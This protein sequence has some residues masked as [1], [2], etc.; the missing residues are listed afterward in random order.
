MRSSVGTGRSETAMS[1]YKTFLKLSLGTTPGPGSSG[2][3]AKAHQG[4]QKLSSRSP[5]RQF[6]FYPLAPAREGSEESVLNFSKAARHR[7]TW[8]CKPFR[9]SSV[10]SGI[11]VAG[12]FKVLG[13]GVETELVPPADY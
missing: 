7:A 13:F 3:V 12:E 11:G 4:I 9:A 2:L 1:C 8:C 6:L 5:A 10:A